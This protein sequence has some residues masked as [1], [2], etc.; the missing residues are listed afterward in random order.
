MENIREKL[1]KLE[2]Q[3]RQHWMKYMIDNISNGESVERWRKQM[4]IDYK[5]L[6]EKEKDSDRVWAD[7][8][9][10]IITKHNWETAFKPKGN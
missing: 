7:K 9:L 4:K 8:V 1:A 10:L 5:E 3:Q 6:T 2:H